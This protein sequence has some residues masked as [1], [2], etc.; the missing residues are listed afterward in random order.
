MQSVDPPLREHIF[1][2]YSMD[3][4]RRNMEI[5]QKRANEAMRLYRFLQ[6]M[7]DDLSDLLDRKQ[8]LAERD[9]DS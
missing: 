4:I 1:S 8:E 3:A 6:G 7:A 2:T 9:E 5:Y